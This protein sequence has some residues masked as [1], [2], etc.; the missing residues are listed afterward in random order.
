MRSKAAPRTKPPEARRAELMNAAQR[1]FLR[2]GVGAT[3]I[4]RITDAAGVAKGTFYLYFSAKED[5]RAALGERFAQAL[6]AGIEAA[7]ADVPSGDWP[8]KLDAWARG[9][10]SAYLDAIRLDDVLFYDAHPPSRAG[11]TDNVIVDHLTA[12]LRAGGAAGA[13]S[14]PDP[15]VAALFLFSGLHGV[16]HAAH[17]AGARIDRQALSRLVAR[18]CFRAV[19][20]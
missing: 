19:M 18:L 11:A 17:G 4:E 3:S 20:G 16:V 9:A 6:L 13:W 7:I 15:R 10:V 5:I 1:L 2:H 12:L 14:V 8:G